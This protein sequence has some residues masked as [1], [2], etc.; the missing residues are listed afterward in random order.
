MTSTPRRASWWAISSFSC[1]FSEM[2]GDCSPSRSVV[3][4]I[5][6]RFGRPIGRVVLPCGSSFSDFLGGRLR[7]SRPP[8]RYSPRGGGGE[9][10]GRA[11]TTRC[12][13]VATESARRRVRSGDEDDL[14]DVRALGEDPVRLAGAVERHGLV[15]R[16]AHR[17]V[18]RSARAERA[19][20]RLELPRSSQSLSMFSPM[21]AFDSDICLTR[22]KPRSIGS[23]CGSAV[24]E[25]ALLA[26]VARRGAERDEPAAGPQHGRSCAST[27][28][29]RSRRARCRAA[30]PRVHQ[31]SRGSRA[32]G[33]RRARG[34]RVLTRRRR[35]VD[36]GAAALGDL[37]R[38]DA[39]AAGGRV[40]QHALTR[41]QA[42]VAE[43]R[44]PGRGVVDRDRRALLEAQRVGQRR[45]RRP[46]GT[47]TS[48]A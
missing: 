43:Q 36:L 17:A 27:T 45:S 20:P 4:K 47:T 22:L 14:A 12:V 40:D 32:G 9:V 42:A 31:P 10:E 21:T 7:L 35:A 6:T 28:V 19:D 33:R 34:S 23:T 29:R 15:R 25:V 3:S 8:T 13:S 11:G 5:S 38:R 44:R 41:A 16:R 18:R 1:V 26:L 48:S 46:R 30:A 37:R 39:D 2:P 24:Q